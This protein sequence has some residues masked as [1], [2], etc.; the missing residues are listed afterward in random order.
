MSENPIAGGTEQ[1]VGE[2]SATEQAETAETDAEFKID[3]VKK[4]YFA[5]SKLEEGNVLLQRVI[6]AGI[7]P[8]FNFKTDE[9]FPQETHGMLIAP[10]SKR[11]DGTNVTQGIIVAAIPVLESIISFGEKG[12]AFVR[13]SILD[14]CFAK[15]AN[16]VRP[17][18]DGTVASH[19]PF[20][21]EDF[22][23]SKR[24]SDALKAYAKLAPKFVKALK[25]MGLKLMNAQ[26][27]RHVLESAVNAEQQFPKMKQEAW[28]HLID[29][30][31]ATAKLEQLDPTLF[32]NWRK[33]RNET[34]GVSEMELDLADIEIVD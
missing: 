7:T 11:I 13:D 1:S 6:D 29:K 17:R 9:N 2:V 12:E 24:G 4:T 25:R 22:I 16:A 3:D 20:S 28:E 18:D 15:V 31:I 26:L 19:V 32:E 30:M 34:T 8:I 14:T 21:I 33:N 10:I 5:P 23:E 27:L